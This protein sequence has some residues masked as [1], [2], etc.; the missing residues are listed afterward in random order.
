M[1]PKRQ[2]TTLIT[3]TLINNLIFAL[4]GVKFIANGIIFGNGTT[5][6]DWKIEKVTEGGSTSLLT[7][8]YEGGQWVEK[9]G[10]I[11]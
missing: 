2:L 10:D 7:Y 9:G 11:A 5:A 8:R 4:F 3:A 1:P 6:G